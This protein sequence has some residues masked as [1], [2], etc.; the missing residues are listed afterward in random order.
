MAGEQSQS[1][2][3][4]HTGTETMKLQSG[5]SVTVDILGSA[6]KL[7]WDV[8]AQVLWL[9]AFVAFVAAAPVLYFFFGLFCAR[10]GSS[11]FPMIYVFTSPLPVAVWTLFV[12]RWHSVR[13]WQREGRE[14]GVVGSNWRE[15]EAAGLSR[16]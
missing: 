7:V 4:I 5:E 9:L 3:N 8:F 1:E 13:Q 11:D 14:F 2:E 12:C 6:E 10:S 16:S 15:A